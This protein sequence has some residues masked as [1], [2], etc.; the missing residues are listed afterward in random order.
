MFPVLILLNVLLFFVPPDFIKSENVFGDV[1]VAPL[2]H[3]SG[4]NGM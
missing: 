4:D 2:E 3:A 1:K